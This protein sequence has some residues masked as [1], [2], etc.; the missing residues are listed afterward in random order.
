MTFNRSNQIKNLTNTSVGSPLNKLVM[1][2]FLV[3]AASAIFMNSQSAYQEVTK[4]DPTDKEKIQ[5][6]AR[7]CTITE[8]VELKK[9]V[10]NKSD[11][12]QKDSDYMSKIL[13]EAQK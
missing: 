7:N 13:E 5:E 4:P 3:V 10:K 8:Y 2:G 6:C 1:W 12:S 9:Q 11:Q